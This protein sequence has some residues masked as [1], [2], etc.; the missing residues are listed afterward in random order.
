MAQHLSLSHNN[1]NNNNFFNFIQWNARSILYRFHDLEMQSSFYKAFVISETWLT[2]QNT[3][4]LKGFDTVRQDQING[5]GGGVAI[6]ISHLLTYREIRPV[7]DCS[8]KL[9]VY[10]VEIFLAGGS[11]ILVACYRPPP[12]PMRDQYPKTNGGLFSPNSGI[13]AQ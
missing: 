1:N 2:E 13:I 12:P 10:A 4:L 11:L 9:E 5:R 6:L 3:F 8:G 7:Q